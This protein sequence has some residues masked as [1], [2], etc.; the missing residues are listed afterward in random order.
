MIQVISNTPRTLA[1][2]NPKGVVRFGG[3]IC[4]G[5][6]KPIMGHWI[7][8]FADPVLKTRQYC[9]RDGTSYSEGMSNG[10]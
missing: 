2:L 3:R 10:F 5:C 1:E 6:R 7:L 4:M 9:H 8:N